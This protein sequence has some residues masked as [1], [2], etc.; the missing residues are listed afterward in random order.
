ME[1]NNITVY[2]NPT[3][4][5]FIID[6]AYLNSGEAQISI[7]DLSAKR[8][9]EISKSN[10]ERIFRIDAR[11]LYSGLYIIQIQFKGKQPFYKKIV[12]DY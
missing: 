1:L 7:F 10:K 4:G 3:N 9:L 2:P 6:F 8:K 5:D 11:D 12:I